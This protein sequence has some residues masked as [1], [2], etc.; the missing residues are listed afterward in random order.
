[1]ASGDPA[2]PEAAGAVNSGE[3]AQ[4]SEQEFAS[5]WREHSGWKKSALFWLAAI[6]AAFHILNLNYLALDSTLFRIV[7][8]SGGAALGFLL[9][10]AR[11]GEKPGHIP[12]Y[13]WVLAAA[14]VAVGVYLAWDID[15]WQMR[16]GTV[17][18]VWDF[19]AALVGTVLVLEFTRRSSGWALTIIAL[20]FIVYGFGFVGRS[21]PGALHHQGKPFQDWFVQIFSENGVFGQTLEVSS[22][23]IILFVI[24]GVF[25]TRS[26]AGDYFNNLSV[27]LVGWARGGPAKVAVISGAL[28]GSISGSSV[29][30]VVAS[31]AIT[32]P[33]MRRV[34]YDR[35]TAGAIEATS[36]TGGQITPPV[37]G[38]GAFIMAQVLGMPYADIAWA[39][40]FPCILFYIAN[41]SHCHLHA[42]RHGLKGIPRRELPSLGPML[43]R[44]Y[45]VLPIAILIYAFVTGFSPFR[46]ASLAMLAAILVTLAVMGTST[47]PLPAG[48]KLF[49]IVA[50]LVL[51]GI[52]FLL[53]LDINQVTVPGV[54][55]VV[56]FFALAVATLAIALFAGWL[57]KA[58]RGED[59]TAFGLSG[60]AKTFEGGTRDA[61]QLIAVCAAAGI[62]A[63]AIATT[64]IGGRITYVMLAIAGESKLLAMIFTAIIVTVLGMGMP[65]TAAY[66]IAASVVAPGLIRIG[67]EP[68]TAHMFIFYF[69]ILSAITPP[70]AIA[71]FAAAAMAKADPWRTSMLAVR[72]GLAT[73][74]VPFLFFYSPVLLGKGAWVEVAAALASAIVG[75][76]FLACSTEGWLNGPLASAERALLFLGAIGLMIPEIY[77]SIVGLVLGVG[78][79]AYQRWRYG[80]NPADLV[81][82]PK[83][84]ANA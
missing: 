62:V 8:L 59:T 46:A 50:A 2:K 17:A 39:A 80:S 55:P 74:I 83:I 28:F 32:I 47:G 16:V 20:A 15:D 26:G 68:L 51:G 30:N 12:W 36:S 11:R 42:L 22:T 70:V 23:F 44:L 73:F 58:K 6:F 21:M 33:M 64:G 81:P 48:A 66:A 41:Y 79:L 25:L 9:I 75:V 31:G 72:N 1:M 53:L 49:L 71:S 69:A 7:H 27:A 60:L 4:I 10:S 35:A 40:F 84:S 24:F 57:D 14:A 65:T 52:E 34:G 38:A 67:I 63:G 13:D 45:F 61:L 5:S 78:V 82:S 3:V 18:T 54:G 19:V 37:L 77:S 76:Y 56:L 29:A 43:G